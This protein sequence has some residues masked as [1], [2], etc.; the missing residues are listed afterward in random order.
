MTSQGFLSVFRDMFLYLSSHAE[1]YPSSF[2]NVRFE[3]SFEFS[4]VIFNE[5]LSQNYP[6]IKVGVWLQQ[7]LGQ[8]ENVCACGLETHV[9]Y[10]KFMTF[11]FAFPFSVWWCRDEVT[12]QVLH[13]KSR[14]KDYKKWNRL[15]HQMMHRKATWKHGIGEIAKASWGIAPGPHKGRGGAYST[16]YKLPVAMQSSSILHEKWRLAKMLG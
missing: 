2:T 11:H 16:P 12:M 6:T 8:Q 14:E 13:R 9:W 4:N 10:H 5:K 3:R 15:G 1:I 7:H